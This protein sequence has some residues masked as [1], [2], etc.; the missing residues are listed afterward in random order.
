MKN[1]IVDMSNFE[2]YKKAVK[3]F[4]VEKQLI[5]TMEEC[6]ELIHAIAKYVGSGM[7]STPEQE[8]HIAEEVADVFIMLQQVMYMFDN[9]DCVDDYMEQKIKRLRYF[10]DNGKYPQEAL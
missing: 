1:E 5:K 3:K 9:Y 10:I 2:L 6:S 4:G 7:D 8:Y